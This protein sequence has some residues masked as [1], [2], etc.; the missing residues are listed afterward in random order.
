MATPKTPPPTPAE[1]EARMNAIFS[2]GYDPEGAHSQA[3][4]LLIETLAALGYKKG[5][6]IFT[7]AERWY[8]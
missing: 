7:K 5:A 4:D 8:S 2:K 1:F 6:A 3:D